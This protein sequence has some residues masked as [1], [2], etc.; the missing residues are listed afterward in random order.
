MRCKF[1]ERIFKNKHGLH[2]H[3][4][5]CLVKGFKE[6]EIKYVGRR[7]EKALMES[8]ALISINHYPRVFIKFVKKGEIGT[9]FG[10]RYIL[11]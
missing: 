3:W 1:C 8:P 7:K 10:V 2:I 4:F 11:K 5:Y 6:S 9:K